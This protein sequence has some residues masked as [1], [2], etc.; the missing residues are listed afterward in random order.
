M[1][2]SGL[3]DTVVEWTLEG[4]SEE[5]AMQQ[6]EATFKIRHLKMGITLATALLSCEPSVTMTLLVSIFDT[7]KHVYCDCL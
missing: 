4:L 3:L 6:P 1:L 5:K 7:V 2:S